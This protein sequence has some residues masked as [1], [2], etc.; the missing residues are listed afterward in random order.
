MSLQLPEALVCVHAGPNLLAFD[1]SR[2]DGISVEKFRKDSA[3]PVGTKYTCNLPGGVSLYRFFSPL[4]RNC[5][6]L[7][8]YR[9]FKFLSFTHPFYFGIALAVAALPRPP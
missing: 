1:K 2:S 3:S 7:Y 9:A 8:S 5:L 6:S 4:K